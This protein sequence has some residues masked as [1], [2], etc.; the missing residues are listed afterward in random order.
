MIKKVLLC[1]LVFMYLHCSV[2][3]NM[4]ILKDVSKKGDISSDIQYEINEKLINKD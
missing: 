2:K 1:L 4:N 3:G